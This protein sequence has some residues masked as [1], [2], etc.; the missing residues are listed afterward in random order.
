MVE[1]DTDVLDLA[2]RLREI[3]P[4][5]GLDWSETGSYFRVYQHLPDG[6][7]ATV[8]TSVELTPQLIERVR[9]L[10]H[11]GYDYGRELD[12]QDDRAKQNADH[13]LHE[14]VG[15]IGERLAAAIRQDLQAKH[16]VF[17]PRG[18]DG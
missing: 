6:R 16:R 9:M 2:R 7:K 15:E 1:I 17:L 12:R 4:A 8:T 13:R 3:H 10:T 14:Q 11:E 18:L 5:L